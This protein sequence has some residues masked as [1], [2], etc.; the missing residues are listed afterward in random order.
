MLGILMALRNVG[1]VYCMRPVQVD[2]S[3]IVVLS[4]VNRFCTET[5]HEPE[6]SAVMPHVRL[7]GI[8]AV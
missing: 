3:R 7:R 5:H 4:P 6:H 1:M 8:R 2:D